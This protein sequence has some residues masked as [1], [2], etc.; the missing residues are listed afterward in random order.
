MDS[1]VALLLWIIGTLVAGVVAGNLSFL[2]PITYLLG[3][4]VGWFPVLM[5]MFYCRV[6]RDI[7]IAPLIL[8]A[9]LLT[10]L[11]IQEGW[12]GLLTLPL[13]FLVLALILPLELVLGKLVLGWLPSSSTHQDRTMKCTGDRHDE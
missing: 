10:L 12:R 1:L 6:T 2:N 8:I 4:T 11:S 13:A 3:L 7:G 5:W 9:A